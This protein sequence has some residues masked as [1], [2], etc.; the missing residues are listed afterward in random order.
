MITYQLPGFRAQKLLTNVLSPSRISREDWVRL[1]TDCSENGKL[2]P[3]LYH[4]RWEIETT[5]RELKV[6]QGMEECLRSRTPESIQ[7]EVAGHVVL[8]FLV[9]WLMVEAGV[10]HGIDPLRLSFKN[11]LRELI[12][13]HPSLVTASSRWVACTVRKALGSNCPT[14]STLSTRTKLSPTQTV[15]QPQ[16]KIKTPQTKKQNQQSETSS[17]KTTYCKNEKQSL[18]PLGQAQW[19]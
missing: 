8:Y 18:V 6:E 5:Y 9:R 15:H 1:T 12:K 7:F 19:R 14:S 3:G 13:L 2:K 11:A 10:K 16:T 4:R 17:Y